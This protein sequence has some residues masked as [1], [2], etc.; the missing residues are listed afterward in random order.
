MRPESRWARLWYY[1]TVPV[2]WVRMTLHNFDGILHVLDIIKFRPMKSGWLTA[3]HPWVTGT[4]PATG[5]PIWQDNVL[6]RTPP[7]TEWHGDPRFE[8]DPDEVMITKVGQFMAGM[9][10]KSVPVPEIPW[11]PQRRMPHGINYLHGPVHYSSALLIFNDFAE[12]IYHFTDPRFSA[13]IRRFAREEPREILLVFRNRDY[14]PTEFAFLAGFLR[15]VL[16]WFSNSNGPKKRVLWGNP[17][18]Y[19]VVNIITGNW[20]IDTYALKDPAQRH[21][22]ARPPIPAGHY[23]Q[24]GNYQGTRREARWPEKLLAHL[25]ERRIRMRGE[26]ENLFFVDRR[27]CWRSVERMESPSGRD[28]RSGSKDDPRLSDGWSGLGALFDGF[29]GAVETEGAAP[30]VELGFPSIQLLS[31]GVGHP[32]FHVNPGLFGL[33]NAGLAQ[34]AQVFGDIVL[35]RVDLGGQLVHGHWL[36]QQLTNNPPAGLIRERL[37]H[38]DARFRVHR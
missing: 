32:A 19:P 38:F 34:D 2:V 14:D 20:K 27:K 21:R 31:E 4:N 30:E 35:V 37:Q 36:D 16:P 33:D 3:D 8:P 7:A 10:A 25:T 9:V 15:T 28:T 29:E 26:R 24:H 5:R 13:D 12:A 1:L 17:A 22:L 23:F 18:P 6:F 11:G